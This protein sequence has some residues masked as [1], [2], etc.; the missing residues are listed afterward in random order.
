[1]LQESNFRRAWLWADEARQ[2]RRATGILFS[3]RREAWSRRLWQRS[4]GASCG[5]GNARENLF[6][7]RASIYGFLAVGHAKGGGS[8]N[9]IWSDY[10]A[11][12]VASRRAMN[13]GPSYFPFDV[14]LW[15][16]ADIL[17][18]ADETLSPSQR[19]ELVADVYA[20]LDR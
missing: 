3:I 13:V 4:S 7:E 9:L 2:S 1:M 11:A 8:A 10:Q 15:T 5:Q 20:T 14:A 17:Q 19:A 16:P 12:R 18:E 6:V